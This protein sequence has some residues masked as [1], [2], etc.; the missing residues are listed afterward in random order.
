MAGKN[1]S[2]RQKMIGMMYLVLTALLA[3]QV[4]NAVLEK[5]AIIVGT[6]DQVAVDAN[7]KNELVLR[8]ISE[9][10][11]ASQKDNVLKAKENASKVRAL[12]KSTMDNI[13][14]LKTKMIALSNTTE[15]NEA[16]IN[17][18]SMKVATMMIAPKSPEGLAFKKQLDDYVTQVNQLSG[19]SLPTL[20][21]APKDMPMFANDPDH[22]EKDFLTFNFENTP[23]IAA[24]ATVTEIQTE[25]LEYEN[26][27]LEK[28]RELAGAGT[29]KFDQIV[30]MVRPEASVV[31]AGAKYKAD[32]FITASSSAI[33]PEF[34]KDGAKLE[35]TDDP[36]GVKM[37]RVEF[38]AQGGGYDKNGMARKTF[39]ALIELNGEKY[40]KEVEYFVAAPVIRVTT[41]N[42][43][44]LYMECG[45]NVNIEVPALGTNYNPS[46]TANG[47]QLQK[48]DKPGK[49][50]I[51][52]QQR[53]VTI[54]VSNGGVNIGSQQ[55]DVKPVP[56]PHFE[57]KESS[58]K[59]VDMRNGVRGSSLTTLRV[60]AVAEENFKNEVPKD[61][62]Y[63]IRTMEVIHAR[64][65]APINRMT[66]TNESLE[67][68]S[69]RSQFKPGDN[70]VIE[71][72]TVTRRTFLGKDDKVDIGTQI[73]R[74]PIQ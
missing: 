7:R 25:L 1:E 3:L 24:L 35:V 13:N 23:V 42:A 33:V 66:A 60:N 44:T 70:I 72:K 48:G 43:P 20:A 4:S 34:Y 15:V 16:L 32:M 73:F 17:D 47:A 8:A 31:A 61:A 71:V 21:K 57:I 56:K 28:L 49:V 58:G 65:T 5:F 52:P 2:P 53:K 50:T 37:G 59:E 46:F 26:K 51:I 10:A 62:V 74:V 19:L 18:H 22:A 67:L 38:T 36:T 64:G 69:W 14:E 55:F 41:G 63:R 39:K 12:T 30:P 45:N 27:A 29:I 40:E 68:A 54:G 6:L 9:E 11:G